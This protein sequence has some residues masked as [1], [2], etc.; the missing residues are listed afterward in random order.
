MRRPENI[1][2]YAFGILK[3]HLASIGISYESMNRPV[4]AVVNSWNEIVPG[5]AGMREI[6]EAVKKGVLSAGG[7]PLEFNTIAMCDGITQGHSGM[8]YPLPS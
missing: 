1:S 3:T 7:L 6:S 2:D 5:H 4:I 8:Q